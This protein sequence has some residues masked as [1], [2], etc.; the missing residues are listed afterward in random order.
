MSAGIGVH[1]RA[2]WLTDP[3]D[4][5]THAFRHVVAGGLWLALCPAF[6]PADPQ[7]LTD[8]EDEF[9]RCLTC[10]L[11]VAIAHG[12]ELAD[13]LPPEAAGEHERGL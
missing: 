6:V 2:L 12:T 7:T 9:G 4:G 1:L 11:A 3:R 10:A 13:Q 8:P 5:L